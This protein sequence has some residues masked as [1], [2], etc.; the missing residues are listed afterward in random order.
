MNLPLAPLG[1]FSVGTGLALAVLIGFGFGFMLERGGFGSSRRLAAQFYLYDMTVFKVMFTAIVT[2]MLGLF[3]L[4]RLGLVDL[5][6]VWINPTFLW[7]QIVGGFLLGV[8][9]VVSGY[10]PGTAIVA[11]ASGKLDGMLSLAGVGL[12][13]ALYAVL[14]TPALDAF[15]KSGAHGRLLLCDLLHVNANWLALGVTLMAALAFLGADK[16]ERLFAGRAEAGRAP[17][18]TP[19]TRNRVALV[20]LGAGLVLALPPQFAPSAQAGAPRAEEITPM[21]LAR[22]LVEGLTRYV[23]LDTRDP[24][25]FA[26]ASVPGSVSLRPEEL[27]SAAVWSERFSREKSYVLVSAKGDETGFPWAPAGYR[28][29]VLRGG[30]AAWRDK[31]LRAPDSPSALGEEARQEYREQ[32]ALHS[33]FT[34]AAG[35]APAVSAPPA[36]AASEGAAKKKPGGGC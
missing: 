14:Y 9:F 36:P 27:Q 8:G 7:P 31:I 22:G 23:V 18:W 35:S 11:S 10:C 28:L 15:Q 3:G 20:L 34:G 16:V 29:A 25:D 13:I 17:A 24:A 2:A 19:A 6:S 33:Y 12:G 26:E 4:A 5:G 1:G 30:F 32:W 21:D